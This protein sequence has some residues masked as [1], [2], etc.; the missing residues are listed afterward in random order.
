MEILT[1][2]KRTN[3]GNFFQSGENTYWL[4]SVDREYQGRAK[5]P[6]YYLSKMLNAAAEKKTQFISGFFQTREDNIFSY[7]VKNAVGM[8]QFMIAEFQDQGEKLILREK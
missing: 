4:R 7:D 3:A 5:K 6:V 2:T 8:K 1:L